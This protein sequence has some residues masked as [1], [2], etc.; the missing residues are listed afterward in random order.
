MKNLAKL[1]L[2]AAITV[3]TLN[4]ST[5]GSVE[6]VVQDTVKQTAQAVPAQTEP[7]AGEKVTKWLNATGDYISEKAD[8]V[9]DFATE[10]YNKIE[11]A[12]EERQAKEAEVKSVEP[13]DVKATTP[14]TSAQ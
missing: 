10:Q 5:V 12:Y 7:T 8:E 3:A 4:A 9:S 6:P 13:V 14:S 1:S 11:K 2:V